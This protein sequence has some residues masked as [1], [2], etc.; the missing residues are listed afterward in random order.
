MMAGREDIA[1]FFGAVMSEDSARAK[2]CHGFLKDLAG[3]PQ[4]GPATP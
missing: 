3:S 4:A 2:Q 1:D